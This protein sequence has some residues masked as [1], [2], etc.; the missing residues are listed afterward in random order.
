M[1]EDG[2]RIDFSNSAWIEKYVEERVGVFDEDFFLSTAF[3]Y[4]TRSN[5]MI[6]T[7]ATQK[8]VDEV[9][10]HYLLLPGAEQA[11]RNDE[12]SLNISAAG[13]DHSVRIY[14]Y[15]SPISRVVE[16]ELTLESISA[17]KIIT[18]LEEAYPAG[19]LEDINEIQPFTRGDIFGGYV[20]Y[21][22][23]E[24]D[25]YAYPYLPIYS[26]AYLFEG[27]EEDFLNDLEAMNSAY[28]DYR[29][30]ETQDV[31]YYRISGKI[32]SLSYFMTD[33]G[34]EIVSISIQEEGSSRP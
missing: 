10:D 20:R 11:G 15:Y 25:E 19:E 7:Y 1:E 18:D 9:R 4:N 12:T 3:S 17:E 21:R 14:N 5:R 16:L 22:Y 26:R 28:P 13:P 33:S 32:I 30:D 6:L 27:T 23:D 8:S 2:A 34:E 29:Y 24:L 31:Y